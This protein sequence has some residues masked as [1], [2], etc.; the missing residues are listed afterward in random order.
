M[1]AFSFLVVASG[2]WQVVVV[3]IGVRIELIERK[4]SDLERDSRWNLDS[5]DEREL[6][7]GR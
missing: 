7:D 4:V 3:R 6:V 2:C 1:M 5:L